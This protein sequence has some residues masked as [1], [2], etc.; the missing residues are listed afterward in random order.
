M[1]SY[2]AWFK[3]ETL[4]IDRSRYLYPAGMAIPSWSEREWEDLRSLEDLKS[5]VE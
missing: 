2:Q 5:C 1:W 4:D 3:Q